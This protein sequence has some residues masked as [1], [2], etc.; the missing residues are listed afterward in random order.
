MPALIP[1]QIEGAAFLA[2]RAEA[3][4]AD[5]PGFGKSA[6][7][8]NAADMVRAQSVL[9]LTTASARVN[10]VNEFNTWS[11]AGRKCFPAMTTTC[12]IPPG[13]DVA[14]VA[15]SNFTAPHIWR[16]LQ[17]RKWDALI[18]DE[19]HYA[20]NIVSD[21]GDENSVIV[22]T[23]AV[24]GKG[25]LIHTAKQRWPMT[26]TPIPNAPDDIY[27]M[28]RGL[29]PQRLGRYTQYRDFTA[30]FCEIET[31][32]LGHRKVRQIRGGKNEEELRE[33]LRPIMLRRGLKDL[34]PLRCNTYVVAAPQAPDE[35]EIDRD[36]VLRAAQDGDTRTLGMALGTIRR[37]TGI[38]KAP[39]VAAL[40]ADELR[41]GLDKIVLFTWHQEVFDHLTGA[42]QEFGVVGIDGRTPG[43][44][45]QTIVEEFQYE[46]FVRV[47]VAQI[48]AAGEAI[49]LTAACQAL[50]VEASFTPKD[51]HQ[52]VRR[53]LRR[54][55]TRP[56]LV[57]VAALAGSIDEA[58]M[59]IVT[60]KVET[61]RTIMDEEH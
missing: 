43:S 29:F 55:Q 14:V 39:L 41:S 59:R 6:Q 20:A 32:F 45:R 12:D 61:I 46:P 21:V 56:C 28:L 1:E 11:Q 35:S 51:M 48:Q 3:L 33:M 17:A 18:I 7:A 27:P 8:I 22:R 5:L 47:F 34:P 37:V 44:A 19:A 15:W 9:T 2:A 40:V 26:G 4:L 52:S 10:W 24:Y 49:T 36:V 53:I 25:G 38:I 50:Y 58:L 30:H 42:L 31:K 13:T 54:G 23:K 60:R 57:R 16:Q